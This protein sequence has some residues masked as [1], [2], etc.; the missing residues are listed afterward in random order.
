LQ[1][2]GKETAALRKALPR[3]RLDKKKNHIETRSHRGCSLKHQS[4]TLQSAKK[5]SPSLRFGRENGLKKRRKKQVK[6]EKIGPSTTPTLMGSE[7]QEGRAPPR[8]PK[9]N[10]RENV[11]A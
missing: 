9:T 11:N 8:V 2:V 10:E 3:E 7:T 6:K 1:M 5:G 4:E